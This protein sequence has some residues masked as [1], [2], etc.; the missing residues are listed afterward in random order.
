MSTSLSAQSIELLVV[1][2]GFEPTIAVAK[3]LRRPEIHATQVSNVGEVSEAI[4]AGS[5]DAVLMLCTNPDVIGE[6][7]IE[8]AE[9]LQGRI[10]D[11]RIGVILVMPT[12]EGAEDEPPSDGM[13]IVD[14]SISPDELFGRLAVMA[15]YRPVIEQYER[16]LRNMQRLGK[17]L[18]HHFTEIDQEMR[19]ASRLQRDF[20]PRELPDVDGIHI[21][22][23]FRPA[24]WVSGDIY[25]IFR[26]DEDHIG[27]YIADVVGHGMA[28]GLLTMFIKRSVVPKRI[29]GN[30]YEILEPGHVLSQLNDSLWSQNLPNCQFVTTCYCLYNT[31]TH[32]LQVARGGHPYPIRVGASGEV[33]E[34][35]SSGGLMGLF[36]NEQFETVT[37]ELLPGEK[38]LL[39]SDGVEM[40]FLEKREASHAQP[41]YKKEFQSVANL[42][43]AELIDRLGRLLDAEEGSLTPH[44]DVT[45]IA[46]ET[47]KA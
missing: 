18:N 37:T 15:R 3:L 34:I 42:P 19:L 47:A 22:T 11:A 12:A 13:D 4:T 39:Y 33:S 46:L 2:N 24:S 14:P 44:D 27:L 31:R 6:E 32:R 41:R 9:R 5:P 20:L 10:G 40:A 35:R 1:T 8:Q 38:L 7:L 29:Y 30:D 28:A 25:D 17:K 36:E 26:I 45:V 23:I 21:G 43:A 16:E